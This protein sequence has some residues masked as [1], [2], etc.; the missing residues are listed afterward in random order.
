MLQRMRDLSIQASNDSLT[1]NDRQY[2]Q[3]EINQLKDEIDRIAGTTQFNKKRILD[4]S[5]G[6]LWASSDP[7]VRVRINGG[8][9][10][11]DNFGQKVSAEGNYRIEVKASPG[12]CQVQKSNIFEK[13]TTIT[14]STTTNAPTEETIYINLNTVGETSGD[15]WS[16]SGK[17]LRLSGNGRFFIEGTGE[18]TDR[19]ILVEPASDVTVFLS[20]V[21]ID[22]SEIEEACAFDIT[23]AKADVYLDGNNS[24]LSGKS[25][26]GLEVPKGAE[27]TLSSMLGDFETSGKL[28]AEGGARG[29]GI[30]GPSY[31]YS[32]DLGTAGKITIKGG[33]IEAIGKSDDNIN[34]VGGA[35]IGGGETY[36]PDGGGEITIDGGN[37]T[38]Y[39]Y[40]GAGIGAGT[41]ADRGEGNET[42]ITI[43]GG[44]IKAVGHN[45]AGIGGGYNS[46]SGSI[47]IKAGLISGGYIDAE[48]DSGAGAADIGHGPHYTDDDI[49]LAA[50]I[51]SPAKRPIPDSEVKTITSITSISTLSDISIFYNSEGKFLVSQPKTLTITQGDGQTASITLYETDTIEDVARKIN[52]VIAHTFG[53]AKYTDNPNKFCTISDGTKGTSESIYGREDIYNDDGDLTGYN[54]YATMLV[55]SAIPGKD[56]ELSFS[57]DED[58]LK[59]LGLNTIQESTES[60]FTAS[61][62]DAHSGK[63]VTSGA[64]ITGNVI[65]NALTG[66]DIE[67]SSMAGIKSS[68]DEASK[69]FIL[70]GTEY[71]ANIHLKNNGITFQTGAN[72]GEDYGI[73]LGDVSTY[74]LGI[75]GVSVS[76]RDSAA[77][78]TGIIDRA[79]SRISSQ[80]A[81]IGSYINDM[82]YIM[83]N[84]TTTSVNLTSADSRLRDAD[85]AKTMMDFVRL[86]ILNQSGTSMLAQ[87]NQIPQSVMNLFG[88]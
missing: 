71:S 75:S 32:H 49:D 15:G 63:V 10:H 41:L 82:E 6:A 67:F 33:T 13:I 46:T 76:T 36:G 42:S 61:V 34:Y 45:S 51:T 88:N 81:K 86:Q 84:L 70:T 50:N 37:I 43:T 56:G 73:Q 38:A 11:I 59:A 25:R 39:G 17:T 12:Q 29:A 7:G 53:N 77:S 3:L 83:N 62:Y 8:L 20:N 52:D 30:G 26:A 21:N 35:G 16:F 72:K 14:T 40:G 69:R 68:W 79:I 85:M 65:Q 4:G 87:A 19:R 9:T 2:I 58:I 66:V 23:D 80:R 64:K 31:E 48:G 5:S 27:L 24:L 60:R 55:R 44:T 74:S 54:T 1:S 47:K 78:S 57:G 18:T 28:R 22:V